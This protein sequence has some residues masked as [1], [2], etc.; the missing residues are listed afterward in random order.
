MIGFRGSEQALDPSLTLLERMYIRLFGV[1]ASGL[2][3][4]LRHVLPLAKDSYTR[5][6]DAGSGIGV[7][8]MELA[9]MHPRAEVVGLDLEA[10]LVKRGN[11]IAQRAGIGNCRFVAGD[12]TKLVYEEEFDLV[13]SVDNI[14]HVEEDVQ[15]LRNLRSAL[16]PGGHLILHT[17]G[18]YRRWPVFKKCTNFD[19][20]GHVRP[21]YLVA[22]LT[23]KLDEA[24][25]SIEDIH[26]TYGFLETLTNNISYAITGAERRNRYI[27][28]MIFPFL[29]WLS[30]LG[31]TARPSWGAG[32]L[33]QARRPT[34]GSSSEKVVPSS[35]ART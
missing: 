19:V 32:L 13:V 7:F 34:G 17:P 6:L 1:P 23:A 35:K 22:D 33:V 31:R 27:Y 10:N 21:G 9:K 15:A 20:P 3:I 29:L 5:I 11:L 14:E 24:G 8:A 12:V 2:R 28:A 30:L 18:Y 4:R 26:H 16:V 25:L